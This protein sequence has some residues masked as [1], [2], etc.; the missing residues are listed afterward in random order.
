MFSG[1]S[2]VY[3]QHTITQYW[4][5]CMKPFVPVWYGFQLAT[6]YAKQLVQVRKQKTKCMGVSS[7][8]SGVSHQTKVLSSSHDSVVFRSALSQLTCATFIVHISLPCLWISCWRMN[9][10]REMHCPIDDSKFT[11]SD[12]Q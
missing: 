12:Y 4:P 3:R 7:K 9:A 5:G 1:H 2:S 8:I 6:T 11:T 10:V